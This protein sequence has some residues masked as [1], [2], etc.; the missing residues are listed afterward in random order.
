MQSGALWRTAEEGERELEVKMPEF[1]LREKSSLIPGRHR[2]VPPAAG[3][4]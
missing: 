4:C 3:S 1:E 2:A